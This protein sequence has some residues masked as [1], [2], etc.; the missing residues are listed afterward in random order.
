MAAPDADVVMVMG[1][2]V[3]VAVAMGLVVVGVLCCRPP[4]LSSCLLAGCT[5]GYCSQPSSTYRH[6]WG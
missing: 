3:A 2:V 1:L 4:M 5:S 6:S